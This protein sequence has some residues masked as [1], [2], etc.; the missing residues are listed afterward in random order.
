MASTFFYLFTQSFNKSSQNKTDQGSLS[1]K[2]LR[3]SELSS[4]E[5]GK[6]ETKQTGYCK[7]TEEGP[8]TQSANFRV[9]QNHLEGLSNYGPPPIIAYSVVLGCSWI[10]TSNELPGDGDML[11]QDGL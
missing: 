7:S 1:L 6:L 5:V 8:L 9:H 3:I 11:V 2:E 10:F 4:R